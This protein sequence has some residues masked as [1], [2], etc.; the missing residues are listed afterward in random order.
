M[1]EGQYHAF[2]E[3]D[4]P[5]PDLIRDCVHCGFCLSACPT[6][7]ETG[8]ELDSPRGR[9]Y[10]MNAAVNGE[11]PLEG[12]LVKHLDMCLGCLACEPACPS[13]V[14]YGSLIEAG[15]SQIER[16]YERSTFDKYYRS[17]IFSLFPYP[18]RMKLMLPMFYI[19]QKLGLR[20]LIQSTGIIARF[21]QKLSKMEEMLPE[22]KSLTFPPEL[23]EVIHAK[24]EQR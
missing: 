9:I 7:L 17:A 16:R 15:R 1:N 21:S 11:I 2:D 19:Y 6:Y 8:N 24:G 4:K 18:K 14:Q 13:G 20:S 10:L 3:Q 12:S 23:P 22:V 5:S